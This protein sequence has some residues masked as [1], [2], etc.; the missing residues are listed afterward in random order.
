[1]TTPPDVRDLQRPQERDESGL[2]VCREPGL[3]DQV[4]GLDRVLERE[5][6]PDLI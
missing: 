1:M 5:Q 6:A 4:E 2:L 3:E